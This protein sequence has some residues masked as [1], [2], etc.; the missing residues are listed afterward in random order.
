MS[1]RAFAE[2]PRPAVPLEGDAERQ[3]LI[4]PPAGTHVSEADYWARYYEH[5]NGYEWNNGVLEVKPVSDLG[6]FGS[7]STPT[8]MPA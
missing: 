6:Y 1:P 3:P 5:E 7:T 8:A 2:H 4:A